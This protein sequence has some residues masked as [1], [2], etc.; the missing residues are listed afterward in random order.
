MLIKYNWYEISINLLIGQVPMS[1]IKKVL[2]FVATVLWVSSCGSTERFAQRFE[3]MENELGDMRRGQAQLSGRVDELQIQLSVLLRRL[4]E[5][6]KS[7]SGA[8]SQLPPD[9]KVVRVHPEPPAPGKVT[10][11][12]PPGGPSSKK[13]SA[14]RG[15]RGLHPV[16]PGQVRERLPVDH[17]AARRPLMEAGASG[18]EQAE[19]RNPEAETARDYEQAIAAYRAADYDKAIDPL[20]SFAERHAGEALSGD[21]LYFLGMAKLNLGRFEEARREF[22]AVADQYPGNQHAA[23]AL[24]Q[25]AR[26]HEKIGR[27]DQARGVYLQLVQAYPLSREAAEASRKLESI[28]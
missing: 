2:G 9:L 8:E 26:C 4:N 6:A 5:K 27:L 18:E 14:A 17:A 10:N 28:R 19:D 20:R 12:G 22:E 15:A 24:L 23:E 13:P 1:A 7:A 16:D 25:K 11:S 3:Q 21:A